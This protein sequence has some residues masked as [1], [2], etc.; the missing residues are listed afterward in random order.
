MSLYIYIFF[1]ACFSLQPE[2]SSK[3]KFKIPGIV[4][5]KYYYLVIK[6]PLRAKDCQPTAGPMSTYKIE[7][8]DHI[9]SIGIKHC[10]ALFVVLIRNYCYKSRAI[11]LQHEAAWATIPKQHVLNCIK[12]GLA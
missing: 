2:K 4:Q 8:N 6:Y 11:Q 5:F 9:T 7:M 3:E 12:L 10:Q 1:L